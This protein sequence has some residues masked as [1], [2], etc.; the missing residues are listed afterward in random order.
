ME[1]VNSDKLPSSNGCTNDFKETSA[2]KNVKP[3]IPNAENNFPPTLKQDGSSN[4]HN[5]DV[6]PTAIKIL[7]PETY[8]NIGEKNCNVGQKRKIFEENCAHVN[9]GSPC[10]MSKVEIQNGL[11]E[12]VKNESV[13]QLKPLESFQH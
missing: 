12:E 5:V 7:E 11:N 13:T 3:E 9:V 8:S 6:N 10:K 2:I 1:S 4:S